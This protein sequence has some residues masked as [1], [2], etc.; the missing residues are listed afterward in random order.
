MFEIFGY[1]EQNVFDQLAEWSIVILLGYMLPRLVAERTVE[2]SSPFA[3]QILLFLNLDQSLLHLLKLFSQGSLV[4][5]RLADVVRY[6]VGGLLEL[7]LHC[8]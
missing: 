1:F 2:A 5:A 7:G 8:L 6:L 3:D 4:L